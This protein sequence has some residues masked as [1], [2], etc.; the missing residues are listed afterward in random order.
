MFHWMRCGRPGFAE[1]VCS[2]KH[3]MHHVPD[4][5]GHWARYGHRFPGT[6]G[7]N[8][9][10]RGKPCITYVEAF[11]NQHT[12]MRRPNRWTHGFFRPAGP[13]MMGGCSQLARRKESDGKSGGAL[14]TSSKHRR[15]VRGTRKHRWTATNLAGG[16][17]MQRGRTCRKQRAHRDRLHHCLRLRAPP[18]QNH[19]LIS[20]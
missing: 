14:Q 13:V 5:L 17:R 3:S 8:T 10:G 15:S 19:R 4:W 1:Y 7:S 18:R 12:C 6:F 2:H 20:R 16:M 9:N 11:L